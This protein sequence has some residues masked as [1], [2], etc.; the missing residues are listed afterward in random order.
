[1]RR[2]LRTLFVASIVA[3]IGCG[4]SSAGRSLRYAAVDMPASFPATA[5]A[6]RPIT[7][8]KTRFGFHRPPQ[9]V[10]AMVADLQ[11]QCGGGVLRNVDVNLH[12]PFCLTPLPCFGTDDATA[13]CVR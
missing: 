7:V 6:G 12:T 13:E 9:N 5:T 8:S 4:G 2:N 11:Q 3:C 10:Q 1:M